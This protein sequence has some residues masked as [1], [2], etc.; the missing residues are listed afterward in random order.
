VQSLA[1]PFRRCWA[2]GPVVISAPTG[3]GKSTLV[4]VWGAMLAGRVLVVQP[5][6]VACRSLARY[7]AQQQGTALGQGVGYAVRHDEQLSPQSR[8]AFVTPG[9]ALRMIEQGSHRRFGA[10]V[11]DEFHER[12]IELDLLLAL[13]REER[14]LGLVVMS[15]TLDGERLARFLGGTHLQAEGRTFP[16]TVEYAGEPLLPSERE[17]ER[18]V[19]EAVER[20]AAAHP[21]D[22]LVFLPGRAEIGACQAALRPCGELDVVPLHAQLRPEEQ[23]QAFEPGPLRRVILATNVAETSIT[24]PRIGLVIDSGLVRQTRFR[25]ARGYLTLTPI[26]MDSAEQRRGRAGRLSPGHCLRLWSEA[27]ILEPTTP[28]EIH[29]E[30]LPVAVLAAAACGR[31]LGGLGFLDP[32]KPY[33]VTA[34]ESTLRALAALD[35]EGRITPLG[36]R[37]TALPLD[38]HLGRIL[39][40]AEGSPVL[41]EAVDLVAAV[42]AGRPLFIAGPRPA[43]PDD[44]LRSAGC[45]ATALVAAL[46]RGRPGPHRLQPAALAEARAIATQL[47]RLLGLPRPAA[48]PPAAPPPPPLQPHQREL[49]A[50]LVLAVHRRAAYLPRRRKRH[51]AWG[52]GHGEELELGQESAVRQDEAE[53]LAV[54]D[55]RALT[56]KHRQTVQVITCAIPCSAATLRATGLGEVRVGQARRADDR[57]VVEAIR[58]YAGLVLERSEEVPRG[59]LARAG[60]VRLVLA[61]GLFPEALALG[62]ERVAAHNLYQRLKGGGERVQLEDWLAAAVARVG[63]DSGEELALLLSKDLTFPD[64]PPEER[65]WLDRSFP[66]EVSVGDACYAVEYDEQR[67]EATLVKVAGS[68][69][70][71]P[72]EAYLP[73]WPGW[74]LLHRDRSVVR[75][76]RERR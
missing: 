20:M 75:V 50:R 9:I 11:L 28:P 40:A 61:G 74:R 3:S 47:R 45:D 24:L 42:A 22:V 10:V 56:V 70:T 17:L 39:L 43:D 13:L 21:G 73:A 30:A 54:V 25:E 14:S 27:A 52:N 63:L 2:A 59:E 26:A 58:S 7:V 57:L 31:R 41:Q 34:A 35:E 8:I 71:L 15:A 76:L 23:D 6:R 36:R 64:L 1:E 5:R 48:P 16:V 4:P 44:D 67:L 18:R 62:R 33:A 69:T 66:R 68:R 65:A 29:R 38:A 53:V 19:V 51:V 60:V 55:T 12:S 46:R 72:N 37:L 32:P 49:L